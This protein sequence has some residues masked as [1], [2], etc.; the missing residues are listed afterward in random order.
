MD[1]EECN[2][3]S[4]M[5]VSGDSS[6]ERDFSGGP[7]GPTVSTPNSKETSPHRSLSANS[8][9]VELYSDE[10]PGPSNED[11]RVERVEEGGPDQGPTEVAGAYRELSN[12]EGVR[13]PNGKLKCDICG[14]I[15]IGP[16]VLMVHKRSHTGERP[17]QCN[18]CGASFT[19]K[20]NLLRH[21]KLHSGE[22]PFKCPFCSYACRRRDALTGHLRT[23][24]VSSPTVG[25]PYKCSYCGR[26]YKQQSTL[27]E[28]LERCYNYLQSVEP[29]QPNSAQNPGEEIREMDFIPDS[30]LHASSDKMTFID[31]LAGSITKR[32]RS[33]P[34]KFVG[35][36]HIHYDDADSH[37]GDV[38]VLHGPRGEYGPG[39]GAVD[40][41]QPLHLPSAH[42]SCL[43]ELRSVHAAA[44]MAG[45]FG[46]RLDQT[47]VGAGPGAAG[48]G[49]REAAEG[50]ED[51][52]AGR[53]SPSNG[54]QDSTDT[55]S[56]P[57]EACSSNNGHLLPNSSD[58][59]AAPAPHYR[60]SPTHAKDREVKREDG[61]Q[62]APPPRGPAPGS[63]T[64]PSSTSREMLRVVDG[65]G[66]TVRCFR[67]DHCRVLFL[68]HVMFTIH[69]GCHGFR[70]PLECNICGHRSRDRYEFSSH[71]VRGEHIL[72]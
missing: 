18:Q 43:S 30:P 6:M 48:A 25:K 72:D 52:P 27:E 26:S 19:Q 64:A 20:G 9:K 60:H 66:R 36:K 56:M 12:H 44:H 54:C 55:E 47:G 70:Q 5:S 8:I 14:M 3:Q 39:G 59:H 67:C 10:D 58:H 2:G 24:A 28:H 11:E 41:L 29:R 33:M 34:Q 62:A 49:R 38:E 53:S 31:R 42:P 71:I 21:I 16:N 51:L 65:E 13:L 61:G 32:K 45:A 4:Y 35:Q 23:H 7:G 68:D 46:L 57:D 37:P 22:K 40:T 17:F 69:M 1:V 15:C 50:H 63:P